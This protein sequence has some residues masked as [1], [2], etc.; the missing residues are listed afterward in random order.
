[1]PFA[2]IQGYTLLK[3]RLVSMAKAQKVPHAQLFWGGEGSA[4][5]PLALAFMAYLNCQRRLE[6]D[7]CGQCASCR[8]MQKLVH[9]D[10]KLI[11]PTS[12]TKKIKGQD[13]VSTN[14][15]DTWRSFLREY[16]YGNDTDWSYYLNSENKQ[17][18]IS[19]EETNKIIQAVSL[20]AFEGAYKIVLI[21]LPE[22]LH[23]TA[24]NALLKVIEEPP[25]H[26]LFLLVSVHP[27]K[28]LGT[29][30]SRTQ[31]IYI[32]AFTDKA[33]ANVLLQRFTLNQEQLAQ[34]TLLAD[35]N[36]NKALKLVDNVTG[37][38]F[39]HFKSWM[40][41]CYACNLTQLVAQATSFHEMSKAGQQD[42]LAYALHMLR[43]TLVLHFTQ[44]SV[45]RVANAER[46][47]T[48]KL[49]Q[50]LTHWQ[51]KTW[52]DWLN[53]A[54]HHIARHINPKI[55]YLDLSLRIVRTFRA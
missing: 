25:P 20:K 35:G 33:L 49:R 28:I 53:Q 54:S 27:D 14:F 1:M 7:A 46:E 17:L 5:L 38:Y 8:K 16:P 10:V 22:Y 37:D 18:N 44:E 39:D 40:R 9:P 50:T 23:V 42:F 13:V 41:L 48:K 15:L 21:W 43:E 29:I 45:T 4:S 32:P 6:D 36:L 51:I 2:A 24:A 34:I 47:F 55:L 11:F 30:R 12:P 31:Q 3:Q 52:I 19:K 26:T